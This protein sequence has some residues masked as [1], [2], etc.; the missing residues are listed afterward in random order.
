[1]IH[2]YHLF[3]DLDGVLASYDE[4]FFSLFG[5]NSMEWERKGKTVWDAIAAA[6]RFFEDMPVIPGAIEFW[7]ELHKLHLDPVILTSCGRSSFHQGL[8]SKMVWCQKHLKIEDREH[9]VLTN[10][11]IV[12]PVKAGWSKAAFAR[13]ETD[14]LI[15]DWDKN[16]AAW[17]VAGGT[18]IHHTSF[19]K[20]LAEL[21]RVMK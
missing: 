20:S 21:K 18:A 17:E 2:K 5:C 7:H 16:C 6:P 11:P 13:D 8:R 4:H 12:I 14:I 9:H 19:E 3:V 1:M 10:G 15:D